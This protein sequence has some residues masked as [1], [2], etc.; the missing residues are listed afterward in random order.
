MIR[1]IKEGN[2]N[3]SKDGFKYKTICNNCDC[4][5]MFDSLDLN[6]K[7]SNICGTKLDN[8]IIEVNCPCCKKSITGV[9]DAFINKELFKEETNNFFD[10]H[11]AICACTKCGH[12]FCI[13]FKTNIN[14]Y[15]YICLDSD[16]N[17]GKTY[18]ENV[19]CPKC[20]TVIRIE[21]DIDFYFMERNKNEN[22]MSAEEIKEVKHICDKLNKEHMGELGNKDTLCGKIG[23]WSMDNDVDNEKVNHKILTLNQ[24]KNYIN[25]L[26]QDTER[27]TKLNEVLELFSEGCCENSFY[28]DEPFNAILDLLEFIFDD[29]ENQLIRYFVYE[30]EF[31]SKYEDGCV[32][33]D[34]GDMGYGTQIIK[35]NNVEELYDYLVENLFN[36]S[37]KE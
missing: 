37:G 13:D 9:E 21:E 7:D 10:N 1:I 36:K 8:Y 33:G 16:S 2:I 32:V 22:H 15:I 35:M 28:Y 4:E 26:K 29:V 3:N 18:F 24:F 23:G 12:D 5:F 31:G 27:F 20:N 6:F 19:I 30:L 34:M 25:F 17:S 11:I 14:K